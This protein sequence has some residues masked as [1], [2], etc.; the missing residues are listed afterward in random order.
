LTKKGISLHR[1]V[2]LNYIDNPYNKP[3]VN[4]INGIKTDNR[5]F[6]LE[7]VTNQENAIHAIK[8][9]LRDEA[10][11]K[12]RIDNQK[13]VIHLASGIFYDSLKIACES[14]NINYG[15]AR[16]YINR[17]GKNNFCLCYV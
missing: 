5:V 7:W 15:S 11:K 14:L 2:A 16:N 1:L 10:H 4:H 13:Q 12:A 6:N 9:G 3:Q 17:R 8:S